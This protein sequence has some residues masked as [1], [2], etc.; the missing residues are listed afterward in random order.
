M[1]VIAHDQADV[2]SDPDNHLDSEDD[3][4]NEIAVPLFSR[5]CS[6]PRVIGDHCRVDVASVSRSRFCVDFQSAAWRRLSCQFRVVG[7]MTI[8]VVDCVA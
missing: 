5:G 8:A 2:D 7:A 1:E 6:C 3:Q 4:T